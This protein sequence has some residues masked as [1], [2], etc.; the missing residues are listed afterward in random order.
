VGR[1]KPGREAEPPSKRRI[2]WPGWTG[3]GGKTV[4]DWLQL[5]SALAIPVVIALAGLYFE[6]QLDERQR[7]SD[8][9]QAQAEQALEKQRAQDTTLEA[10]LGQMGTL[11]LH[12]NLRNPEDD[13]E[14]ETL[15]QARTLTV[16]ARLGSDLEQG[17]ARKRVVIQFLY[18]ASLIGSL[19]GS[20]DPVISLKE[21]DLA[22][23]DLS[24]A[25]LAGADLSGA[26]LSGAD[27][28]SWVF[29]S[30]LYEDG[31]DLSGADLRE[32]DLF[33]A[34][35]SKTNLSRANLN[36]A[37]LG[38]VDAKK[39]GSAR[40]KAR[41]KSQGSRRSHHAR[42]NAAYRA[43]RHAAV[44]T[45]AVVQPQRHLAAQLSGDGQLSIP[46]RPGREPTR[47]HR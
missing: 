24:G 9:R 21:A 27:L 10:Y 7:T 25:T 43:L 2:A 33:Q 45:R 6:G 47:V 44:R 11:L 30:T 31:A 8:E 15:A 22:G 18:E 19:I 34:N 29:S 37:D 17:P 4:W 42:R 28:Y 12:E 3:F 1:K 46:R 16:L 26:D 14:V 38:E 41:A 13:S 23:V 32:A 5:F 36:Y 35:L 40:A 20:N 39:Y